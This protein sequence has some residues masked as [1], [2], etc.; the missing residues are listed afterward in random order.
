MEP[1]GPQPAVHQERGDVTGYRYFSVTRV[2]EAR[3]VSTTLIQPGST[4]RLGC[5]ALR[6]KRLAR[7]N[8]GQ[9]VVLVPAGRELSC[10]RA[11]ARVA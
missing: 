11:W 4:F 3:N 10:H 5:D 2:G 9:R 8:G 7:A 6:W 1:A